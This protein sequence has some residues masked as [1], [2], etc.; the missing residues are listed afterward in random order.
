MMEELV[1][2]TFLA[3]YSIS[4]KLLNGDPGF[5]FLL[6]AVICSSTSNTR[7]G[8]VEPV[9]GNSYPLNSPS[10]I[11]VEFQ[12]VTWSA[13]YRNQ[14]DSGFRDSSFFCPWAMSTV[15]ENATLCD[16]LPS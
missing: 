13:K 8:C 12:S 9:A 1:I 14:R 11:S 10:L 6:E 3:I 5:F 2:E 16:I 15:H 7:Q 4:R